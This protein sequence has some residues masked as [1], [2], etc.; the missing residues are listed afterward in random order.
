MTF[1]QCSMNRVAEG[2]SKPWA[3]RSELKSPAYT[4]CWSEVPRVR[5]Y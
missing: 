2:Y 1:G 3:I 4:S 5:M